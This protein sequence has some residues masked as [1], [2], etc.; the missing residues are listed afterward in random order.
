MASIFF[1]SISKNIE[2]MKFPLFNSCLSALLTSKTIF[3]KDFV[4]IISEIFFVSCVMMNQA[5]IP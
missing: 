1:F 3:S 5:F 2:V 4:L